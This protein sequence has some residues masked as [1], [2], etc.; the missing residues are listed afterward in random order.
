MRYDEDG[1]NEGR[2]Q[3]QFSIFTSASWWRLLNTRVELLLLF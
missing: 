2:F 1:I 3:M